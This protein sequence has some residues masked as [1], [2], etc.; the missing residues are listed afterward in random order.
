MIKISTWIERKPK[1]KP[2]S[3]D[4]LTERILKIRGI[5]EDSMDDFIAPTSDLENDWKDIRNMK[6]AVNIFN[7]IVKTNGNVVI[8]G[9]PDADGVTSLAILFN[10]FTK[11]LL[12]IN[13]DYIYG[14]RDS[15]HGISEQIEQSKTLFEK[16]P[17]LY[18]FNSCNLEKIASADLLIIVDSSSNDIDGVK[19]VLNI[20]PDLKVIILDHHEFIDL[21][22]EKSMDDMQNT[23]IVNIQHSKD[24]S[25]NKSL[26][27][28]GLAYKFIR[29][30]DETLDLNI[31]YQSSYFLDL[32]AV[33]MIG[34]MM[35]VDVYEN[36][37]LISQGL[38]N[39][40]NVGL[41]RI[42]KGA[43]VNLY[44]YNTKDI[45]FSV[46]PL[47]NG[48]A[49]MG[50]IELAIQILICDTD[51]EA[52][53]LR[54][55]MDKLNKERQ[56]IQK[57]LA[58]KF[59]SQINLD[60][61]VLILLDSDSNKSFNGLVAQTIAQKYQRP[62][63]VVRDYNGMCMGSGRSYGGIN[64]KEHLDELDYVKAVGHNQS[65]GI[66]FPSNKL[67]E[68]QDYVN[69][70]FETKLKKDRV[71]YYDIELD[72]ND[73]MWYNINEIEKLNYITGSG[74]PEITVLVSNAMVSDKSVIGKTQET[75]K[76]TVEDELVL[77]KFKVNEDW[78][79]DVELFDTVSAIGTPL[80]NV[81]YNFGTKETTK[82]PQVIIQD[83]SK[84][85]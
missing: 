73:E 4:N 26:S 38:Q 46:A 47:I 3:T 27:G 48:S 35:R 6:T 45:G 74:F 80:I 25:I 23:T 75:V 81:F 55:K 52:K 17:E 70:V 33:G 12:P 13:V 69:R 76:I 78:C 40:N 11:N 43:K 36:R 85:S 50:Q 63:F 21:E 84:G 72:I 51:K 9:D 15:G 53:P 39:V 14:Q 24:N 28:A 41:L 79:S 49:R 1:I 60:N 42:L 8:S 20:K 71:F 58:E 61:K 56:S 77:I 64:T 65:H 83:I 16:E 2:R 19:R 32:V 34:D 59:E 62:C 29:G 67:N 10:Y 7:E 31:E 18:N 68:L 37:Y 44:T 54:L 82:T 57:E 66:E 30:L 22:T 5:S